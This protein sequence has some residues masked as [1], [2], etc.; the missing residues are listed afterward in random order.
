MEKLTNEKLDKLGIKLYMVEPSTRTFGGIVIDK[1]TEFEDMEEVD[2]T[3]EENGHYRKIKIEQTLKNFV[4]TTYVT[5]SM[6]IEGYETEETKKS[7]QD[8]NVLNKEKLLLIFTGE[9]GWGVPDRKLIKPEDSIK[10]LELI[11]NK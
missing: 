10:H 9:E 3:I 2:N 6:K 4:L 5:S 7:I 11:K 8:L 1:D